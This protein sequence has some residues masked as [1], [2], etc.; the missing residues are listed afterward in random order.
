MAIWVGHP[1]ITVSLYI[2]KGIIP[3]LMGNM[4]G[5]ALFCGGYYYMMYAWRQDIVME[6]RLRLPLQRVMQEEAELKNVQPVRR[7]SEG[8]LSSDSRKEGPSQV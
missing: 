4:I 1:S 8:S 2:W 7:S 3:V 5:G 6:E